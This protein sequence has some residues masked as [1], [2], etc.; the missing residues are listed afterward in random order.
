MFQ[1][2]HTRTQLTGSQM[3]RGECTSGTGADISPPVRLGD[4]PGAPATV[5]GGR[6]T[7]GAHAG[8]GEG[9]VGAETSKALARPLLGRTSEPAAPHTLGGGKPHGARWEG[10]GSAR[11]PRLPAAAGRESA[12]QRAA[13]D[14]SLGWGGHSGHWQAQQAARQAA[15]PAAL[16]RGSLVGVDGDHRGLNRGAASTA[17]QRRARAAWS[18]L[19]PAQRD[20]RKSHAGWG[21]GSAGASAGASPAANRLG[22]QRKKQHT[23][24]SASYEPAGGGG[25]Y[26][27]APATAGA[28]GAHPQPELHGL[29]KAAQIFKD[30]WVK[31][32]VKKAFQFQEH[33]GDGY[34]DDFRDGD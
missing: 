25:L 26:F 29:S 21:G 10:A 2:S 20:A 9:W 28:A 12:A 31:H 1:S 19:T 24:H 18:R 13:R 22:K 33:H 4:A 23:V 16:L 27:Q 17:Q 8:P 34:G 3:Q 7:H 6:P 11:K 30:L 32:N 15:A 5:E 14:E